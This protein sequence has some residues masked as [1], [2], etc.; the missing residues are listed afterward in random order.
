MVGTLM[1]RVVEAGCTV[2][3]FGLPASSTTARAGAAERE[4]ELNAWLDGAYA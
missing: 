1:L 2:A 3:L 4:A